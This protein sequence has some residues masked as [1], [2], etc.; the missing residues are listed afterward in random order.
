MWFSVVCCLSLVSSGYFLL[1]AD[2]SH[3]HMKCCHGLHTKLPITWAVVVFAC[4]LYIVVV[5]VF[6]T[7]TSLF[8]LPLLIDISIAVKRRTRAVT[9]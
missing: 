3:T 1:R 8:C 5:V 7:G 9:L 6:S 2:C 4:V